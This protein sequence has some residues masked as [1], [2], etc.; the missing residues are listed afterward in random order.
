M[1]AVRRVAVMEIEIASEDRR[2][3]GSVKGGD[4]MDRVG[5]SIA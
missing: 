3:R 1:I 4:E 5:G 2:N